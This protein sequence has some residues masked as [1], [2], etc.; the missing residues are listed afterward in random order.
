MIVNSLKQQSIISDLTTGSQFWQKRPARQNNDFR[1]NH[2]FF[3]IYLIYAKGFFYL[4][5]SNLGKLDFAALACD[6]NRAFVPFL[7]RS[8][9]C[10]RFDEQLTAQVL[11]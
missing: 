6:A 8:L 5:L 11:E 4:P 3:Q 1:G 9:A 7:E 10:L 2:D